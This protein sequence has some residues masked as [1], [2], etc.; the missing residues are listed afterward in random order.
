LFGTEAEAIPNFPSAPQ[1]KITKDADKSVQ[2]A[3]SALQCLLEAK[4]AV[5]LQCD[6]I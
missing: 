3:N 1:A 6:E 4:G 2:T 5:L